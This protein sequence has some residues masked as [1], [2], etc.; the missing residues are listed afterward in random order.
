[1]IIEQRETT[2]AYRCPHCGCGI[3][4]LVGVFRLGA[5]R[6]V[7]KCQCGHSEMT[8]TKSSD[9]KI[10]LEVPCLICRTPHNY[11]LTDSLFFSEKLFLLPCHV[12]GLDI[13]FIGAQSEVSDALE[14][15]GEE[16]GRMLD[17]AG[18]DAFDV[19]HR[20]DEAK[21]LPDAHIYDIVNL[22]V[23]ELEYDHKIHCDCETG[24]Y[25][26]YF[27]ED[28]EHIVVECESCG[29]SCEFPADSVAAATEFLNI[30]EIT[31]EN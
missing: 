25:R 6:L 19:F 14:A 22:L 2:V 24:P 15:S 4:S 12:S 29:A 16:L 30:D 20:E 13:C 8:L 10:R 3:M 1:M 28:G 5:D 11:T 21:E 26:V 9:G 27:S 7:L 18:I 31:L 23:R 17:D